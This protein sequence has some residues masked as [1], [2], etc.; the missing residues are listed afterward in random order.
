MGSAR[1]LPLTGQW[2][3]HSINKGRSEPDSS[4]YPT[5]PASGLRS[6]LVGCRMRDFTGCIPISGRKIVPP[7]FLAIL[8]LALALMLGCNSAKVDPGETEV[9]S[10]PP[11]FAD[12]T[13]TVGLRFTHDPGPLDGSY[14]MPQI[15]GSGGALFDLHGD[16]RLDV[17]LIQN[18]GPG[19]ARNQLFR[20]RRDGTFEDVSAGSGLDVAGYGMGVA[21]ADVNNDG[22]PDV[23]LTGYGGDRLF[24]N[25]GKGQF[26]EVTKEAG[27]DNPVWGT[28]ASFIDYDRD[29]WLDLV[30]VNYLLLDPRLPCYDPAMKRAYC[31]PQS[32]P[33]VVTRLFRNRGRDATGKWL[34]YE[35]RTVA[36]GLASVQGAGLGVLCADFDGDGWPDIFVANDLRANHLWINQKD[37]TFKEEAIARGVAFNALGQ[38]QANM[39]IAYGDIDGGGLPALFV[40]HL[41]NEYHG[42]WKQ[43]PRGMFQERTA[44]AGLTA[45]RWRGTGFGT[46]LGDFD[47]DGRLDLAIVN[48]GV[49]R[50]FPETDSYWKPYA[51]RN[52]LFANQGGGVFSDISPQNPAFC[53]EEGV[54]R[55]LVVGDIDGDGGLDLLVTRVGE[56]ARLFRNVAPN[57]GHWL[58]I[59]ALERVPARDAIGAEV[60]VRAGSR[61]WSRLIQSAGSYLCSQDPRAH[62]GLGTVSRIDEVSVLW[63]DGSEEV[64]PGGDVDRVV[65]V[66]KGSG[67]VRPSKKEKP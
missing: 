9:S 20:Q 43:G 35:D 23:Y 1:R 40:T 4:T 47:N 48:G 29:G 36:S 12:V 38:P 50:A 59:R 63:L 62:F 64:F 6:G 10:S 41:T 58:M 25:Q 44:Q 32:F 55:A 21:I 24:L 52:Q 26:R 18:G 67:R 8:A 66:R 14:F 30:V 53:G 60:R 56:S 49:R 61:Q 54:S 51:D 33:T 3:R 11:W 37:G 19:G 57:R 7:L 22:L 39:G 5:G 42:L 17:Y 45:T 31:H 34:G 27:I 13:E 65:V 46:V 15:I 28:S 16:G 2:G